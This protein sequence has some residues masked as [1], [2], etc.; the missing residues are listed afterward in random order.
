VSELIVRSIFHYLLFKQNTK[1]GDDI[2]DLLWLSLRNANE[3][4]LS[5]SNEREFF[6]GAARS[7]RIPFAS[8][9]RDMKEKVQDHLMYA[10]TITLIRTI[11]GR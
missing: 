7:I 6:R 8:S 5:P 4:A 1:G 11:K 10:K 2:G 3:C 9:A